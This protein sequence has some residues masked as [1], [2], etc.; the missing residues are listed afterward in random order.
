MCS[1]D[2]VVDV[3][4]LKASYSEYSDGFDIGGYFWVEQQIIEASGFN[5]A[6]KQSFE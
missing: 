4:E 2:L 1:F 5:Y 3:K 6:V